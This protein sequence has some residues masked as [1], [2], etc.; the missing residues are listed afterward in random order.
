[1]RRVVRSSRLL[2]AVLLGINLMQIP[3]I[4]SAD[5]IGRLFSTADERSQL[6]ELRKKQKITHKEVLL[7]KSGQKAEEATFLESYFLNG[8]VKRSNGQVSIWVNGVLVEDQA[9]NESFRVHR[10]SGAKNRVTLDVDGKTR[11]VRLKPGQAWDPVTG[12]V[13]DGLRSVT[14]PKVTEQQTEVQEMDEL[15]GGQGGA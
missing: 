15:S 1:M 11:R 4:T 13:V 8:I 7:E 10:R 3:G 12:K 5:E 9:S 14:Q 2:V 6:D